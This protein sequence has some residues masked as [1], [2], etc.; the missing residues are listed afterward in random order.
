MELRRLAAE[1]GDTDSVLEEAAGVGV[2]AV[3]G[4]RIGVEIAVGEHGAYRR[5]ELRVRDLVDEE[6]EEALEL[7][8]V[9]AQRGCQARRVDIRRVERPH[10]EL[11]PVAEPLDPSEH[12]HGVPFREASVEELDVVPDPRVDVPARVDELEHEVRRA[13]LRSQPSLR[14][15][16]EHA[17]DDA[18]GNEVGDHPAESIHRFGSLKSMSRISPFRALRYDVGTAGPLQDLVAPPY[19]VIDEGS[20]FALLH[21]SKYNIVHLTLPVSPELA[22]QELAEWR[23]KKVLLEEPEALWWI[24]QEYT[25]P[26]GVARRREGIAGSIEATPY[27]E[28]KV[29]PHELTHAEVKEVR[30]A[31]LR[32]TRTQL[33]PIFL[34][35]DADVPV[36]GPG[37]DPVMEVDDRG[38]ATRVWRLESDGIDL[39]VP[40]LIADG[41]HRYETAV[42][43]R[44]EEP[45]ATHTFA[46]LVSSRSPGV[47]IFPT[48]RIVQEVGVNPFGFMTSIWDATSLA[49]YRAGNFFRLESDDTL[50]T[51][52]IEQYEL[53]G[54]EYTADA[55]EAV[56]AVDDELAQLAFLVRAPS[57]GQVFEYATRGETMPQKTTFFYPKLTSGLLLHPV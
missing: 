2:V 45:T 40:F 21:Q 35:Y 25:G 34:L 5:G 36:E 29:M 57:V 20:H 19:D 6:L 39:D 51:R 54:V 12:A 14:L 10:L 55:E 13:A 26:D 22:A 28:G 11:Q 47:E 18:V 32:A 43:F 48:H 15:D 27:P 46:V 7:R 17:L 50:D 38:V 8:G 4:R 9:P 49:M 53:E 23:E 31:I 44:E 16:G 1:G 56:Q 37:G 30:L 52:A 33:E 24:E 3:G 41:H 42:A